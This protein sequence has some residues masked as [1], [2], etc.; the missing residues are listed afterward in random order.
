MRCRNCGQEVNEAA[1]FCENCGATVAGVAVGAAVA[2]R[3]TCRN[4][5][6]QL[7]QAAAY[8]RECGTPVPDAEYERLESPTAV[9]LM[10]ARVVILSLV[11]AGLYL[12]FWSYQ[13]WKQ[14]QTEDSR[15]HYPVWHALTLLVPFYAYFRFSAHLELINDNAR[16]LGITTVSVGACIA[17]LIAS[18]IAS[19][20]GN[21][22]NDATAGATAMAVS[23]VLT[24]MLLYLAQRPLNAYWTEKHG[25]VQETP[26]H[27]AEAVLAV[28]GVLAWVG[29]ATG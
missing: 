7:T 16:R 2:S 20:F 15:D 29:A 21:L 22:T 10:P 8:C 25:R 5:G 27:W 28:I 9:Q 4:C 6:A 19:W 12:L 24:A 3:D 18:N 23:A 14:L 17:L 1:R 11:T 13:T 26:F